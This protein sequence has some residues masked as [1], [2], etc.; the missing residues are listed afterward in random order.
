M[1]LF[2]LF[3][4]MRQDREIDNA[5]TEADRHA[6]RSRTTA[7]ELD[8]LRTA[9]DRLALTN[10]ALWELLRERTEL[11]D[12]ELTAKI[13]E[14]DERDGHA[15]GRMSRET[16]KC[17]SCGRPNSAGRGRCLYCGELMVARKR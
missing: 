13:R 2:S 15:D 11:T 7:A 9:V 8:E 1:G 5:R 14:V 4:D 17:P 12:D 6:A 10:Q 3:W 16:E